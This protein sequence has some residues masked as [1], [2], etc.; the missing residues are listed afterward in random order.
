M[1]TL[2]IWVIILAIGWG[3]VKAFSGEKSAD[4]RP[5]TEAQVDFALALLK[6]AGYPTDIMDDSFQKLGASAADCRG[7]VEDWL[8]GMDITSCSKLIDSLKAEKEAQRE[9]A[10]AEHDAKRNSERKD[11]M[12]QISQIIAEK[13]DRY[14]RRKEY[15]G[16]I[17]PDDADRILAYIE[18]MKEHYQPYKEW[19][20]N[21][22]MK[23]FARAGVE[24]KQKGKSPRV[25]LEAYMS[26]DGKAHTF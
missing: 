17:G 25:Q 26:V 10:T 1:E 6:E 13:V 14:A 21:E 8:E 24:A 4:T 12:R 20:I 11:L 5:A 18:A 2:I 7:S 15:K 3:I 19:Q 23:K 22:I 9:K 16:C